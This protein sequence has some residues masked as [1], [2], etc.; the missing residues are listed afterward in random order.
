M[1]GVGVGPFLVAGATGRVGRL[2]AR[3]LLALGRDVRLSSRRRPEEATLNRAA[4]V[5][6]DFGDPATMQ[7]AAKGTRSAF[8]YTPEV[9]LSGPLAEAVV[10][11]GVTHAVLLS[12]A[13]V[14]KVLNDDNPV[15]RR[16]RAFEMAMAATGLDLTILRPDTFASNA[17][18][19][20]APIRR[21]AIV[22]L[23]F[24]RAMRNPIHECDIAAAA[25][26]ALC[27][28]LLHAGRAYSLTGPE[29]LTQAE[30]VRAIA[31]V[32]GHD[33]VLRELS[34]QEALAEWTSGERALPPAVAQRL[35]DY[36][37]KSVTVVPALSAD[38][39]RVVGR[40]ARTFS[41]WCRDHREAFVLRWHP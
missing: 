13:A 24:P 25:V 21:D 35:I 1:K 14:A 29:V 20:A 2:V 9:S 40:P 27:D 32:V 33:I 7:E 16:H 23:P 31:E 6:S 22:R 36:L 30:Q 15:A 41:A 12:S 37:E 34:P 38:L 10:S 17:L 26:S 11:A 5:P 3:Q 28:P 8:L 18:Q 39:A 19:W 4:W